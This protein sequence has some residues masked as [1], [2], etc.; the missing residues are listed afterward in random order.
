MSD[1]IALLRS[2]HLEQIASPR[3]I[4]SRPATNYVAEFIGRTNLLRGTVSD[5]VVRCHSLTWHAPLPDG[6]VTFSLRPENVRLSSSSTSTGLVRFQC[7]VRNHVF[8]GATDLLQV[9]CDDGFIFSVRIASGRDLGGIINLE[10][11]PEDAVQVQD[12]EP[13]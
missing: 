4:Y 1:R 7:K 8:H 9:E 12:S 2:G 6:P 5:G 13:L 10:F 11:S 3:E